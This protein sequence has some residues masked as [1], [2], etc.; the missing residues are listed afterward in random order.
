MIEFACPHCNRPMHVPDDAAGKNGICKQCGNRVTVPGQRA[1]V[2]PASQTNSVVSSIVEPTA[3]SRGQSVPADRKSSKV[4]TVLTSL[5]LLNRK[6][7]LSLAAELSILKVL[8]ALA[9]AA[10]FVLVLRSG[11]SIWLDVKNAVASRYNPENIRETAHWIGDILKPL[12]SIHSSNE[13][14]RNDAVQA[15][16][17]RLNSA[18]EQLLGEEVSWEMR[19]EV[20]EDSVY[21]MG[22]YSDKG[23]EALL[24]LDRDELRHA[25]AMAEEDRRAIRDP[26]RYR[27]ALEA[28]LQEAKAIAAA[29]KKNVKEGEKE[30]WAAVC[31]TGPRSRIITMGVLDDRPQE[32]W[33]GR[34]RFFLLKIPEKVS[35]ADAAKLTDRAKVN[36]KI[37]GFEIGRYRDDERNER[38]LL[39]LFLTDVALESMESE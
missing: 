24:L 34:E 4:L 21:L 31:G 23:D 33:R 1:V 10:C 19:C 15:E 13:V 27:V 3:E 7:P 9:T 36:G 28:A 20:S 18:L 11:V 39:Y 8:M 16:M 29:H 30:Y 6:S 38:F 22:A 12:K 35:R 37:K 2:G 17:A 32:S 26:E 5:A 14:A 25:R